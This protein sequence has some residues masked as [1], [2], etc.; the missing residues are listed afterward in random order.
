MPTCSSSVAQHTFRI[1]AA[2][3][4]LGTVCIPVPSTSQTSARPMD[5]RPTSPEA[6]SELPRKKMGR[7]RRRS[8]ELAPVLNCQV[9]MPARATCNTCTH[10]CITAMPYVQCCI[11]YAEPVKQTPEDITSYSIH[12]TTC[13]SWRQEDCIIHVIC[14]SLHCVIEFKTM[15]FCDRHTISNNPMGYAMSV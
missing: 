9:A 8:Q 5:H 1:W 6:S 13:C 3:S 15:M 12:V 2:S 11:A 4:G 7:T 10:I 14:H